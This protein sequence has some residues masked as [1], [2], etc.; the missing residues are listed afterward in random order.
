MRSGVHHRI[1]RNLDRVSE[2][3]SAFEERSDSIRGGG[4]GELILRTAEATMMMQMDDV[5]D[6][7]VGLDL[8]KGTV[9]EMLFKL[10]DEGKPIGISG[11]SGMSRMSGINRAAVKRKVSWQDPVALSV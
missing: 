11:I 7:R 6:F 5:G 8:S 4:G 9:K 10:E 2:M 1:D 3:L